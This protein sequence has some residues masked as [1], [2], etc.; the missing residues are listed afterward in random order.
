MFPGKSFQTALN[1]SSSNISE[2]WRKK[3]LKINEILRYPEADR[4]KIKKIKKVEWIDGLRNWYFETDAPDGRVWNAA[5]LPQ[6]INTSQLVGKG[7]RRIPYLALR[8]SPHRFG[9]AT[10]PWEDI[11]RPDQGFCR[12]FGD[13]KPGSKKAEEFLGNRRLLEAFVQHRGDREE[14]LKSPPVLVFEAVPHGGRTKG[15]VMFNGFGVIMRAELVV[16][17]DDKSSRT[18]PNYVYEIALL[19]LAEDNEDLNWEWINARRDSAIDLE[20]CLA[21]APSSWKKWVEGGSATLEGLR[22]N[23]LTR[24]VVS[25][26]MQKPPSGSEEDQIL[27]EVYSYYENKKHKFEALAEFVTA[28]I[29][30]D[31]QIQYQ[32][33]WITQSGGDGGVDFVGAIDL[34]PVGLMKSSKQVVL[35]QAKC[36]KLSKST[37]GLHIAR[38]AA[39]LRRG[40]IGVYVTTSYFSQHVQREVLVDRYPVVLV[41]G[42]RLATVLRRYL[43]DN[44]VS[45]SVLLDQLSEHYVTRIGYGDPEAILA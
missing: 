30:R 4:E 40:W 5:Q 12:Y 45:L 16:Q 38:L 22:R 27:N 35:G 33:G 26:R 28:G 43:L 20:A 17:R 18:F 3:V 42:A 10:T 41:D 13:A 9:S 8:S 24:N 32:P 2:S 7:Q 6:G 31:Q 37:N 21:L 29:F 1:K 14:R 11:H 25:E 34:D 19:D 44:G 36:E 39:R 15:Q 23:V